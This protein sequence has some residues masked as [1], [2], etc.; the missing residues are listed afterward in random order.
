MILSLDKQQKLNPEWLRE[1]ENF[2]N[3][4]GKKKKSKLVKKIFVETYIEYIREGMNPKD[5]L[6]KAKMIALCF[7]V[8]QQW[9]IKTCP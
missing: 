9:H 6:Q 1:F 3:K 2:L 7:F 8:S 4:N 5:A